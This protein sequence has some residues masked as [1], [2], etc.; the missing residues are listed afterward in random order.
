MGAGPSGPSGPIGPP[1]PSGPPGAQGLA[2]IAGAIGPQGPPGTAGAIGP[3]GTAGAIGPPGTAGAIGP[4]GPPGTAGPPGNDGAAGPPGPPG[5]PGPQGPQG[6][7]SGS[8]G[9]PISQPTGQ[10]VN[11]G[12][13][14]NAQNIYN[15]FSKIAP[16]D[17]D[18]QKAILQLAI[19]ADQ[20][21]LLLVPQ[22]QSCPPGTY[23]GGGPPMNGFNGCFPNGMSQQ[24][25]NAKIRPA[26]QNAANICSAS[27]K[28]DNPPPPPPQYVSNYSVKPSTFAPEPYSRYD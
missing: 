15:V 20:M 21:G 13:S 27:V 1:G 25:F 3:P 16:Q 17:P 5:P 4:P 22:D 19:Q 12:L 24:D 28:R 11:Q 6:Y 10:A 23:N 14:P 9:A 2:G 26:M 7:S 8:V 18:C